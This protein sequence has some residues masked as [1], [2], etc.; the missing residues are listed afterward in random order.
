MECNIV[1]H[2]GRDVVDVFVKNEAEHWLLPD[3][4]WNLEPRPLLSVPREIW[5]LMVGS[6]IELSF[7][8]R[9]E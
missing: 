4:F 7:D 8:E 6:A 3:G 1:L 5:E 9:K 2:E